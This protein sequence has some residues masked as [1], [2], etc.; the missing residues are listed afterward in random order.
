MSTLPVHPK[1]NGKRD[2]TY[3]LAILGV[4]HSLYECSNEGRFKSC[5]LSSREGGQELWSDH[6]LGIVGDEN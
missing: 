1:Q 5:P 3:H 4:A 6:L 2:L